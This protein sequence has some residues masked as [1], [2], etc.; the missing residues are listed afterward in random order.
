MGAWKNSTETQQSSHAQRYELEVKNVR[1][2]AEE[3]RM[4]DSQGES[5]PAKG[6]RKR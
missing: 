1:S 3:A 4:R 6:V 5:D 2:D